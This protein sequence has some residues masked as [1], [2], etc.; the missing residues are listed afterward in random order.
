MPSN[1]KTFV[2]DRPDDQPCYEA[3]EFDMLRNMMIASVE[4]RYRDA[5]MIK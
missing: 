4:E 2:S 1:I 5:G 3:E